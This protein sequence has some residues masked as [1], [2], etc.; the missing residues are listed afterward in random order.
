MSEY[1]MRISAKGFFFDDR[2]RVLLIKG[3]H[4]DKNDGQE[5]WAT[6][7]G[8]VEEGENLKQAA[9]R[10]FLEETG[11]NGQADKI[12]FVQDYTNYWQK[13][14]FEVFFSGKVLKKDANVKPDHESKFFSEEEFKKII[15]LPEDINPF[16]LKKGVWYS[17]KLNR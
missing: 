9:E 3:L 4:R 16:K 10:E 14:S 2:G 5:Y 17:E 12:V 15:F 8:G 6:P 1:K 11:Y 7:G 13:R